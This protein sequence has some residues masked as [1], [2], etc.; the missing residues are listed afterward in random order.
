MNTSETGRDFHREF[1]CL[2]DETARY[3]HRVRVFDDF[4]HCAAIA[5]HNGIP[6]QYSGALEQYYLKI[7]R[8]Y[9]RTD[10]DRMAGCW[11]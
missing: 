3:H 10:T 8:G 1:V 4:I 5:L 11:H 6:C 7:I 9:E 2:F